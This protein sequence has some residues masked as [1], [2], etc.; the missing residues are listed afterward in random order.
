MGVE[1]FFKKVHR[2]SLLKQKPLATSLEPLKSAETAKINQIAGKK[3]Y[4]YRATGYKT[5]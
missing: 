2:T 4:R 5:S 1:E 3:Y